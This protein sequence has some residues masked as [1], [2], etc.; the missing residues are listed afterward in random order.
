MKGVIIIIDNGE[1]FEGTFSQFRDCFFSNA[2]YRT[3]K[4]WCNDMGS[5][6]KFVR[7]EIK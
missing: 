7:R 4:D 1:T 6:V 2:N 3:I 5:T